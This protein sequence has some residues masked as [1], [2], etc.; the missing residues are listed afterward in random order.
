VFKLCKSITAKSL[1][2]RLV[3]IQPIGKGDWIVKVSSAFDQILVVAYHI[4]RYEG[5]VKC[6]TS[7]L[8]AV[9]YVETLLLS[10]SSTY[11]Q[12]D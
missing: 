1:I 8:E 9:V 7:E 11:K 5:H 3:S 4:T 2:V 10:G 12:K 6:F